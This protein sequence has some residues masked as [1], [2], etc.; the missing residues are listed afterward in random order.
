MLAKTTMTDSYFF[1]LEGFIVIA[2]IVALS[3]AITKF[4][5]K[6]SSKYLIE[7]IAQLDQTTYQHIANVPFKQLNQTID[8]LVLSTYGIFIIERKKFNGKISGDQVDSNWIIQTKKDQQTIPNPLANLTAK[9]SSIAQELNMQEKYF[10]PIIAFSN[11]TELEVEQKLINKSVAN[12]DQINETIQFYQT[13]K[14]SKEKISEL[15]TLLETM[16][17]DK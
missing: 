3:L 5:R 10:Y 12:Y 15:I 6:V 4:S 16:K 13:P 2:V 17:L 1:G 14:I 8:H 9:I 11:S 7:K